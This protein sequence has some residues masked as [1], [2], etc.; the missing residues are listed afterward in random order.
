[1]AESNREI[2]EETPQPSGRIGVSEAAHRL[3][4]TYHQTH[5]LLLRGTL[6]GAKGEDGW[7]VESDSVERYLAAQGAA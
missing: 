6:E 7:Y 2:G 1:M 4:L 3:K 5:A